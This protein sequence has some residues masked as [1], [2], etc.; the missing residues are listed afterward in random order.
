MHPLVSSRETHPLLTS[1][2]PPANSFRL[3]PNPFPNISQNNRFENRR[4]QS[5]QKS[6]SRGA[7]AAAADDAERG[8]G[9]QLRGGTGAGA[10]AERANERGAAARAGHAQA[11]DP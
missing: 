5:P 11:N 9:G 3:D 2:A 6:D 10:R 1:N 7:H 8:G 4:K